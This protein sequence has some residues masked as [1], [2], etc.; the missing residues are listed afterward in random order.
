MIVLAEEHLPSTKSDLMQTPFLNRTPETFES[1]ITNSH[2]QFHSCEVGRHGVK[3][4]LSESI[5]RFQRTHAPSLGV[6]KSGLARRLQNPGLKEN[7]HPASHGESQASS[8]FDELRID[9][10][11]NHKAPNAHYVTD[12]SVFSSHFPEGHQLDAGFVEAY[13]LQDELGSGGYGFVMTANDR[14]AGHEVAVKFII[15]DKM[16]EHAWMED[17]SLGRLP[18]E[19]VLLSS[20][21]HESIVKYLSLFEDDLFFYMVR[22]PSEI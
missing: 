3:R 18:T 15:K 21:N 17:K 19:V 16:P 6:W 20:I 1:I 22:S 13:Q 8:L 14:I 10:E 12:A 7:Y 5:S 2:E 9:F 4:S 11:H